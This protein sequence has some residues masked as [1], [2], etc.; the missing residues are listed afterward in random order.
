MIPTPRR[1]SAAG[2]L[3]ES[4][5]SM[6]G[7]MELRIVGNRGAPAS[8]SSPVRFVSDESPADVA[9]DDCAGSPGTVGNRG[10][11]PFA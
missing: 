2:A 4:G 9:G 1:L 7:C 5:T 3:P 11:V 6:P 8:S 10:S